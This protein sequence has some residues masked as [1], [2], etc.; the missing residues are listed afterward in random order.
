MTGTLEIGNFT[1]FSGPNAA[2]GPEGEAGCIAAANLINTAGGPLGHQ[3]NCI[4]VDTR[5]DP[6]DAVPAANQLLAAHPNLIGV[7]GPTT[8]ESDATVPIFDRAKMVM[9]ATTGEARFDKSTFKYFWR[10]V[11]ADDV[12]GYGLAIWAKKQGYTRV[13]AVFGA[14]A[15]SQGSAPT[16]VAGFQKLGGTVTANVSIALD[17]ASYRTEVTQVL[18]G[19][20][21]AIFTEEDPQTAGTFFQ[22]LKQLH[23]S[24]LP[25]IGTHPTL[26]HGWLTAVTSAIPG[27]ELVANYVSVAFYAAPSGPAWDVY[28]TSLLSAGSA[29]DNAK[30]WL[31]DPYSMTGY[32]GVNIMALAM[33]V[34]NSTDPAVYNDSILKVTTH[35]SGATIVHNYKDGKAAL[36]AGKTI[37][38]VGTGGE[39]DFDQ[40]HNS[41]GGFAIYKLNPSA[42]TRDDQAVL[43]DQ[44]SPDEINKVKG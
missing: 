36:A 15:S 43:V 38:Y 25:I 44:I 16:S 42:P 6:A 29:I 26:D 30:Q 32:D 33:I 19:N 28:Q 14:D 1:S 24:L 12:N 11:P 10:N 39:L 22:E 37:D 7:L 27:S 41:P 4:S 17:Q 34:A 23:G 2:F 13:A 8:D 35:S 18:A 5:G 31:S 3:M 21:Q 40:W 20:P 9:F